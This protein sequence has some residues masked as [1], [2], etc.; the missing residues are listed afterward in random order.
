MLASQI[1]DARQVH[2]NSQACGKVKF[3]VWENVLK[4]LKRKPLLSQRSPPHV[5]EAGIAV[6]SPP[7]ILELLVAEAS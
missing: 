2:S 5:Q 7:S 6:Y 1:Y 4:E 3:A